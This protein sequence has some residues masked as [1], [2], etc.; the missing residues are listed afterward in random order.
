VVEPPLAEED[1]LDLTRVE[2][3][4]LEDDH[5][6][7]AAVEAVEPD[8]G[9]P[10]YTPLPRSDAR[11]VAGPVAN[12]RQAVPRERGHHQL[13]PLAVRQ[14]AIGRRIHDLRQVVVVPHVDTVPGVALDAHPRPPGL[15]HAD[16]VVGS[17]SHL[18][19]DPRSQ[20]VGPRLGA[21]HAHPEAR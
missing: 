1:L 19:L 3:D 4:A 12:E 5:V 18:G 21:Q 11:D 10:A 14:N 17:D 8:A 2:F 20:L 7:G 6:V 16:E 15:R 13:T 9:P